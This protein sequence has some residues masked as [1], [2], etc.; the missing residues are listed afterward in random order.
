MKYMDSN[1]NLCL[2]VQLLDSIALGIYKGELSGWS[3][4]RDSYQG[5]ERKGIEPILV[6]LS[7]LKEELLLWRHYQAK[8]MQKQMRLI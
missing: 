1:L 8:A 7:T 4:F 3:D 5:R 2:N 6:H